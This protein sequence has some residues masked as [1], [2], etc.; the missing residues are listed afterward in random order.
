MK[1]MVFMAAFVAATAA[2][3]ACSSNDDLV[4]QKPD[5]P[6]EQI[7][8]KVPMTIIVSDLASRGTDLTAST[9]EGFTLYSTMTN[10]WKTGKLFGKDAGGNWTT[11][12]DLNWPDGNE[13]TFYGINDVTNLTKDQGNPV[14][15][16][17]VSETNVQFSYTLPTDYAEQVDLL[18]AKTTGSSTTGDP[19]GSISVTFNHALAQI[20]AIKVYCNI[21]KVTNSGDKVN[22]RFRINGI[23]LG[24]LK[25][26]GIY[27]FDASTPWA[28]SGNDEVFE[29]PLKTSDLTFDNMGFSPAAKT[30]NA[31]NAITLPLN[32]GDNGLYLIPQVAAGVIASVGSS[33]EV[34]NAYA[35]LDAQVFFYS[36]YINDPGNGGAY[37]VGADL[38]QGFDWNETSSDAVGFGKIRVPLKF[39]LTPGNGYTLVLDISRAV[40]Y[41]NEGSDA[42]SAVSEPIFAGAT[43]TVG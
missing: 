16:P 28:V 24:G 15:P 35:E 2:F 17:S 43:I 26:V 19:A 40:I 33:Y 29:I 41:E 42:G 32:T 21:D 4:Q 25:S 5:V 7:E 27:T 22:Y 31:A 11:N 3:V 13:Y 6:E 36:D 12:D 37:R 9:L 18:V 8:E 34:N 10:A 1:K 20:N 23:R 39:T 30:A 38:W 14:L